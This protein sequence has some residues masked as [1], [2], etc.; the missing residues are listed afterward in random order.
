MT[1]AKHSGLDV[2]DVGGIV[3]TTVEPL[4]ADVLAKGTAEL[5]ENAPPP[6]LGS[7]LGAA[8]DR[9]D[10]RAEKR[11]R[12]LATPWP[13]FNDTLPGRGFW[14][15]LHVL[16]AGTGV[17]KSTWALQLALHAAENGAAV[18]YAGLE[19]DD[20]QIALRLVGE[21]ASV[22]WSNLYTGEA[23]DEQRRRA[24]EAA[25][26]LEELAFHVEHGAPGGWSAS[27]LQALAE[28]MR[29][30]YPAPRP[31]L[32]V[33]DFLQILGPELE[34]GRQDLRERIGRAAYVS[35]HVAR[36]HDATV[37]LVSSLA[38]DKYDAGQLVTEAR[39]GG[40]A[41]E[42]EVDRYI[43]N[44]DA[45]V[46]VGKESGEIEYAADSVTVALRCDVEPSN[47][48]LGRRVLFAVP[49][50]RAGRPSWAELRFN[51]HRFA[52]APDAG[53]ELV[54]T[55]QRERA[56][57]SAEKAAKRDKPTKKNSRQWESAENDREIR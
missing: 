38:R 43:R 13:S 5:E 10:A 3:N 56:A 21:R 19:L 7:I 39:L 52:D 42:S 15:G 27:D 57:S 32:L 20:A 4:P 29:A 44:P 37:L 25:G 26:E 31:L 2:W 14:P 6:S 45:I 51:G 48:H 34:A 18:A 33:V 53:R 35:R 54:E 1:E 16:V 41:V 23:S 17:G 46:G 47:A 22:R 30:T 55:W 36:E 50:L 9:M 28:R 24:R 12:P 11:E 40:E 49:K 8:L